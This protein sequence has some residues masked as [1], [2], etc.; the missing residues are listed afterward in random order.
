VS[1]KYSPSPTL[2]NAIIGL[3][4]LEDEILIKALIIGFKF[5][6]NIHFAEK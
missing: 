5:Q 2:F 4:F 1:L 3:H 6:Y